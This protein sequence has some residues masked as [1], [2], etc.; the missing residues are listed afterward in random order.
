[1]IEELAN[2][3]AIK[4]LVRLHNRPL[5]YVDV[6]VY[7][8]YCPAQ[9]IHDAILEQHTDALI[10]HGVDNGL[11]VRP[12]DKLRINSLLDIS[13]PVYEGKRPLV[14][15]AVCTRN[16]STDLDICLAS[17]TQINYPNLEILVVDNAPE[18]GLTKQLVA[19][20]YPDFRYILEPMPGLNMARNRALADA[21][22]KIIA[23]TD[24]DVVVDSGWVTAL[25]NTFNDD[26]EVTA[27]TGLVVPYELETKA[28]LLF[29]EYGGFGRG[30]ERRWV[31]FNPNG[32]NSWALR[33]TGQLGTGANMAFR[34]TILQQIGGF[35]PALDVGTVTNGGGD[36]DLFFRVLK[37]GYTLV[38]EPSAIVRHRHRREYAHL[39]QQIGNNG[40]GLYAYFMRNFLMYRDERKPF[41]IL[42]VW[43]FLWWHMRRLSLSFLRPGFPRDLIWA[44][45]SGVFKG[46]GRYQKAR[47]NARENGI[48]FFAEPNGLKRPLPSQEKTNHAS[49][50]RT[51]DLQHPLTALDDVAEYASVRLFILWDGLLLG[52]VEIANEYRAISQNRLR[53]AIVAHLYLKVIEPERTYSDDQLYGRLMNAVA[54]KYAFDAEFSSLS[55]LQLSNNVSVSVVVATYDRPDDLQVCLGNLL[56]QEGKRPL[57]IIIVDNNPSSRKTPPIVA[58]FPDV[59]LVNEPRQ[60]LAYARNAGINVS[61]GDIIVAT[62]DDVLMPTDWLEKLVAPFAQNDVMIVTGNVLPSE[63]ETE[64]QYRFEAYGGLGRGF[65]PKRVDGSWFEAFRLRGVPTWT[66]GATANAAF[67]ATIFDHPEIG[68]MDEALGP[69][70]P[71][72]VGEDTYLFYKVLKAGFT[73]VYE[74][75]AYVMHGHRRTS[76]ALRRQLYNYSKGH[77]SYHLTTWLRDHDWRAIFHVY[78]Q[79]PLWNVKRLILW[80]LRRDDYPLHLILLE[81]WGNLIGPIVLWRSRWRVRRQ[82]NSQQYVS[83][84]DV[85]V[86]AREKSA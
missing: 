39:S 84:Q 76:T 67:R 56:A 42:G 66:L 83:V 82:G 71:S 59:I 85:R 70:L 63:I 22:G 51:I 48:E 80:A 52:Q 31:H 44:E 33:G 17:L 57:E 86:Q 9:A 41:L 68:L 32:D 10:R 65:E 60:G 79:L 74:P 5:G 47:R 40:I 28:Q 36:L 18:D 4:G 64:A 46:L 54:E 38:Y 50:T 27:V 73:L 77:V 26:L 61:H 13:A 45:M 6:S 53:D 49:A 81:I 72:G 37:H 19:Q 34:R 12:G 30:F 78:G 75:T 58:Q 11:T 62:D 3:R 7:G 2:Y 35:D 24:D 55:Q 20:K 29:E 69:G 25:V 1:D 15:V 23:Y 16:R 8:D 21:Q 43:W 14:T